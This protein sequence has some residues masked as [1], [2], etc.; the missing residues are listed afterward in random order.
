MKTAENADDGGAADPQSSSSLDTTALSRSSPGL[1]GAP[2]K[3]LA[4]THRDNDV[5]AN[6]GGDYPAAAICSYLAGCAAGRRNGWVRAR[7][8]DGVCRS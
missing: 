6:A 5:K 1:T 7:R 2:T 8:G 3:T 4:I